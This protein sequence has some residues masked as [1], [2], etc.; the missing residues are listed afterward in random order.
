MP[1]YHQ[2]VI[3]TNGLPSIISYTGASPVALVSIE[4]YGSR[5]ENI[6]V[7]TNP[8]KLQQFSKPQLT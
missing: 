3:I 8:D 4:P 6:Y 2:E 5:I 1:D 7:Q